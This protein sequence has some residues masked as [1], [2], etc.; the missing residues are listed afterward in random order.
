MWRCKVGEDPINEDVYY[1]I[2]V[3]K[4]AKRKIILTI[5]GE[6]NISRWKDFNRLGIIDNEAVQSLIDLINEDGSLCLN[7]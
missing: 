4:E 2:L 6:K 3:N 1:V 7:L 5:D